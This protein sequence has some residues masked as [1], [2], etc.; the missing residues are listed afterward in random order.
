MIRLCVSR[1]VKKRVIYIPRYHYT[2]NTSWRIQ[3][4]FETLNQLVSLG[5]G[6]VE[7][8]KRKQLL[9]SK[10][11][12]TCKAQAVHLF[13]IYLVIKKQDEDFE[14]FDPLV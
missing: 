9:N 8:K 10:E 12:K 14:L 6:T 2:V 4:C 1:E 11:T 3:K 13:K 7:I 5:T